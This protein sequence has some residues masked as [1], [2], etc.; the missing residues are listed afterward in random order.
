MPPLSVVIIA[1]DEADRIGDAIRSVAFADEVVVLDSGSTD[2]TVAVAQA[3]GARVLGTDW[4]GHVQQ[5]NRALAEATHP[6]VLS[7]D[8][9]ERVS[10][11]LA[12][13]IL[14]ALV[15][16]PPVEGFTVDRRNVWLGR[17]LRGGRF[18]LDRRVRLVRRQAARCVGEDPHDSLEVQGP[19]AHLEGP[20]EHEPYRDLGEHLATIDTYTARWAQSTR[21]RAHWWDL[22]FR[23]PWAFVRGY[24]LGGGFRDGVSGLVVAAL[25]ALYTLLKWSRL[26]TR[27]REE[28]ATI[29]SGPVTDRRTDP[30]TAGS[31]TAPGTGP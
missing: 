27:Q 26:W 12:R 6:W 28:T 20:L 8:A 21:R 2:G 1:R 10:P 17:V 9:D 22:A 4:P 30:A 31:G 18:A 7:L 15:E 23:P 29:P 3:L 24:V 5:K 19:T 14:G 11:E 25:G 16:D 13:A